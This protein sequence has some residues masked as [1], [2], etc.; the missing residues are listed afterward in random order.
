MSLYT[1]RSLLLTGSAAIAVAACTQADVDD[2]L[3]PGDA[4]PIVVAPNTGGGSGTSNF[5]TRSTAPS[6]STACPTGTSFITNVSLPSGATTSFCSLTPVGSNT[7]TGAVNIPFSADPLLI[8][9]TVFIGDGTDGSADVT[10]AEGQQFVSASQ[11]GIVDL[12]VIRPGSEATLVGTATNPIVFTSAQDL[13]DDLTAN[14]STNTGEW[15]GLAINGTAPLNECDD[16]TATPGTA[17]CELEGEGGSGFYGGGDVGDDSGDFQYIR[18]HNAGFQFTSSNELNGIALQGVGNGTTFSFVQVDNGADDGFEWFGGTVDTSNLIVTGAGDD[19]FDWTDGWQGSMQFGLVVQ[20]EGN[21]NGIEGD[22][23]GGSSGALRD[24]EPRSN[25]DLSNLTLIGGGTDVVRDSSGDPILVPDEDNPG[26]FETVPQSGEGLLLREG[27]DANVANFIITGF[28]EGFEWDDEGTNIDPTINSI[29]VAGNATNLKDSEE[30]FNA[31]DDNVQGAATSLNGVLPGAA[32][33]N[34]ISVSPETVNPLFDMDADYVGAFSPTESL[35]DNWTTGWAVNIPFA[36]P[37][38]CPTGTSEITTDTPTAINLNRTE[39]RTC[40]INN[41]VIGDVNLTAG[42]LYRLDGTVFVGEDQGSDAASPTAGADS[43]SLTVEPGVTIFGNQQSGIVDLLV[44][45]RGSTIDVNGTSAAPVI[46]TSRSDLENGADSVRAGVTGEIGGIAINGRAPLNECDD[47]TATEGTAGCELEGEGGSGFYGGGL[48]ADDSGSINF[49][50]V[51]YAGFQFTS[52]NE[53]NAIALQG[54]GSDT[55]ID[56]VQ[57]INGAD[58]GIEW[59]GGT[60]SAKH[61]VISGAGDDSLDW[62]DGWTGSVQ[63]AIV[64]QNEGDDNGIEGDGN[65]GSSGALRDNLPRSR[66]VIANFTFIGGGN[67]VIR[68][69]GGTPI[70]VPDEDNPGSFVTVPQAG[71]GA[72]FREGSDGALI[73]GTIQSFGEGLEYDDES[74]FSPDSE[75]RYVSI[76]LADNAT[77]QKDTDDLPVANL[78][79][80][81]EYATS[82]LG[83]VAGFT[84]SLAPGSNETTTTAANPVTVCDAEFASIPAAETTAAATNANAVLPSPCGNLDAATYIGAMED[85]SD[86]WFAGWTLGL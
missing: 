58:D 53:L 68:D 31:G 79:D 72:I 18:V 26:D 47:A 76:V 67:D 33:T 11:P 27:T 82:T 9:G 21:D 43:G 28:G 85:A 1:I 5:A 73:N 20:D 69:S 3:T 38:G 51:R 24:N 64:V 2:V 46:L 50:Q 70:L 75:P 6:T 55:D 7:I 83:P 19:S 62:T 77:Q 12:L 32:E 59:F 34:A 56:F 30:I 49:M 22:N 48:P 23:N 86:T 61:V 60:A 78:V 10:F 80:V 81:D 84:T 16:A 15:G 71:E 54:V 63:Y 4:T 8:N 40:V 42:N 66:P 37:A 45:S 36:S 74:G 44:V 17:G 39:A 41:P 52:S 13:E 35:S 29:I 57:V 65:G 14:G 25:P